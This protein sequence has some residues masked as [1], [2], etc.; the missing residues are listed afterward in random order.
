MLSNQKLVEKRR[1]KEIKRKDKRRA[2]FLQ[3]VKALKGKKQKLLKE[4]AMKVIMNNPN[5]LQKFITNQSKLNAQK[6]APNVVPDKKP[7][8]VA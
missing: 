3:T 4:R 5:L 7:G 1:R 2:L 8:N 6:Q